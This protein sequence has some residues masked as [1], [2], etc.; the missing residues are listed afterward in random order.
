MNRPPALARSVLDTIGN[1]PLVEL[2]RIPALLGLEGRLLVKL[3]F[4]SPGASKKDRVALELIRRAKAEG[5]LRDGQPVVELTSGN[6]GT[7]LAIVCRALGHPFVAV[8]SRGNSIERARMM[9]A[10]GAEVVLVDQAPGSVP[11]QVT[12]EDLRLVDEAASRIVSDR[13]AFRARQFE[14]AGSVL[15]HE[16]HTGPELW[17]QSLGAIDAYVDC[18]GTSGSLTGVARALKARKPSVRIYAVEPRNAAVLAGCPTADPSRRHCIQ[19]AG[20]GRADADLPLFDRSLVDGFIA[21]SDQEAA[22]SSRL[23]SRE[24]GIFA[25]TSTGAHLAAA[26][27]LLLGPE[28]GGTIAFLACDTGL[29][30]LSTDLFP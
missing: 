9:A 24:E 17:E 29:K 19:G 30:Y 13:G 23:L 14:R 21:V 18:P 8:M 5:L 26:R 7:G 6:T 3:E 22:D 10:L 28:R 20:Y 25:G 15:A 16:L 2:S 11:G 1:T 4:F 12:G 27:R